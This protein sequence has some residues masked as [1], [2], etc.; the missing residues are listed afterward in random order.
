MEIYS[1]P[2][3]IAVLLLF[4]NLAYCVEYVQSGVTVAIHKDISSRFTTDLWPKF[5]DKLVDTVF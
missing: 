5:A 1:Y 4:I 2:L 3:V